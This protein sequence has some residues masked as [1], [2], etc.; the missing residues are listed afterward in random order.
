MKETISKIKPPSRMYIPLELY[1]VE[2]F[3]KRYDPAD[4]EYIHR[5]VVVEILKKRKNE[6]ATLQSYRGNM[7]KLGIIH[8][9]DAILDELNE[10]E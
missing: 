1:A 4:E 10:E 7:Y 9:L 2:G 3:H 6:V 8:T 5:D